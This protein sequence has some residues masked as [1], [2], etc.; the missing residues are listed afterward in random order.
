ML[1]ERGAV[2]DDY[3]RQDLDAAM[4]YIQRIKRHYINDPDVYKQFLEILARHRPLVNNVG[5]YLCTLI[6]ANAP[7]QG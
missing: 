3:E 6:Y 1:I 4:D 5:F 7:L 2:L